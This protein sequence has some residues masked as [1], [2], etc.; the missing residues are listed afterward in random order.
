MKGPR[1]GRGRRGTEMLID[2]SGVAGFPATT[3]PA[4]SANYFQTPHPPPASVESANQWRSR[5][6]RGAASMP[7]AAGVRA[8]GPHRHGDLLT[9]QAPGG[10]AWKGRGQRAAAPDS[11]CAVLSGWARRAFTVST[12]PLVARAPRRGGEEVSPAMARALEETVSV[13]RFSQQPLT[14]PANVFSAA[15]S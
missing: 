14:P 6:S 1:R 2:S 9:R 5:A 13:N 7:T 8:L 15:R 4:L 12:A 3:T 11:S 10:C